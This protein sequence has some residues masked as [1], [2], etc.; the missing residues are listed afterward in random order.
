MTHAYSHRSRTLFLAGILHAFTHAYQMALIPLYLPI[1][2]FF[3]RDSVDDATL[4]V[5]AMLVAYFLPSYAMG[6]LADRFSRKKLLAIGLALNGL[7]FVGLALAPSY[8]TAIA[9]VI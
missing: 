9:C 7:G 6:I 2:K 8:M 4:L 3:E 1:Q 5:T